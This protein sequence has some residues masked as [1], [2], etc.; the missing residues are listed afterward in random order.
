M[1]VRNKALLVFVIIFIMAGSGYYI[2][3]SKL[4]ESLNSN[5]NTI[6]L[7]GEETS[8]I[9]L[10]GVVKP[11]RLNSRDFIPNIVSDENVGGIKLDEQ[12]K[13]TI[14]L[15]ADSLL[16]EASVQVVSADGEIVYE[17]KGK[18]ASKLIEVGLDSRE[19]NLIVETATWGY[20]EIRY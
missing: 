2:G 9:S 14:A 19:Y 11:A 13:L 15:K 17:W 5:P 7:I 8:V 4:M 20:I 10:Y 6:D 18:K 3:N 16:G 12:Q 1:N